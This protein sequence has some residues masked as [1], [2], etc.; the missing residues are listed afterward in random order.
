MSTRRLIRP[1][2]MLAC[3]WV[4]AGTSAR[5]QLPADLPLSARYAAGLQNAD[6][7]FGATKG[8]ASSLGATSSAIRVLKNCGGSIPDVLK[9]V[10]YV[11]SCRDAASG[12]F[13]ATP[14]G[15]P[16]VHTTAVGLMAW[17]ELLLPR[18][19][20][21]P[22]A[23]GY[24]S[25]HVQTFEDIRI[26]V[27]GLE[28]MG[29]TP[30]ELA[31]RWV[32]Q[33][34]ATSNE[35]GTYGKGLEQARS[36]GGAFAA[37]LR[38]GERA[39]PR[40]RAT[41]AAAIKLGQR[42]DGG[43]SKGAGASDLETT[44]R[45]V[46]CLFMLRS[47]PDLDALSK[48]LGERRHADGSYEVAQGA[49]SSLSGTYFGTTVGGWARQLRGEPALV[50]TAGFQTLFNG[51]DLSGWEG[52]ASLWRVRDGMLVGVSP[53]IKHNEF[54]AS[55]R[56]L[57]DFVLKLTFRLVGGKGN[58][59]VMFR[60]KRVEGREMSGYQ[61]DVGENYW[62]CLYDESRRNKVL[63]PAAADALARLNKTGWN[64]YVIRAEGEHI[65]L[66]LNE[67][68]SVDYK[69]ADAS[70]AKEGRAA[71]QIHAGEAMEVQ[72]KDILVQPQPSP[73]AAGDDHAAGFHLR[74]LTTPDGPRKYVVYVPRGYDAAKAWPA[75]L[76]LHGSGERGV[77]GV[78]AARVGI[79]P[80]ILARPEE[81]G[82]L[83]VIP[84][85]KQ[86]WS[87]ESPDARDALAALDAVRADYKVDARRIVLTGLS[88]GGAG[89]WS[90]GAANPGRFAAVVPICG[91]PSRQQ[92]V[93]LKGVP[94]WTFVGD[95]DGA[96][97]VL[98][99]RDAVAKLRELG[100]N[101][102][103][104]LTEYRGVGHNS[105]DRAYGDPALIAWMLAQSRP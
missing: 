31:A 39:E 63:A 44:Y 54:L 66:M 101:P 17:G 3:V 57:G 60:S 89:S 46:R 7:G 82:A 37:L 28:S 53:G 74:T 86:T 18:E 33:V 68:R 61:A 75:I 15:K 29:G 14:G 13:A 55:E 78:A 34:K 16:D 104:R 85:A 27:A 50:E 42:S 58:S 11:K 93:A 19:A 21:L 41:I 8:G 1:A 98:G 67:R 40:L 97:T 90:I 72:F 12:G 52:D 9:C 77:D 71:V 22:L 51:K 65:T 59:G 20:V 47:A 4:G 2:L 79:G 64:Q 30:A 76:F 70:I 84:Q 96:R 88:M 80:A 81:F 102:G 100:S 92:E 10:A 105:W 43:W 91:G 62:G 5:G 35:N 24:F 69:E 95:H 6:C 83:V 94:I 99:L 36:T 25:E 38:M 23:A 32:E 45:V 56:A 49:E 73:S 26:A 48:F 103:P 87:A